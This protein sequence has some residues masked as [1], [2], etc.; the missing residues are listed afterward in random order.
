MPVEVEVF[1]SPSQ[2]P[3]D[4]VQRKQQ[5]E[6]LMDQISGSFSFMQVCLNFLTWYCLVKRFVYMFFF[7]LCRS[8]FWMGKILH[9][10]FGIREAV[11]LLDW[12]PL[13]L[14]VH[15]PYPLKT[16]HFWP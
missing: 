15:L 13:L 3:K 8:L 5:L 14:L 2:L 6:S 12:S 9:V 4:P 7:F 11:S 1:G 10:A 16:T